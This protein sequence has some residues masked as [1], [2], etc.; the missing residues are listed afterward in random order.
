MKLIK[1]EVLI[2]AHMAAIRTKKALTV[3]VQAGDANQGERYALFLDR[4]QLEVAVESLGVSLKFEISK[5][6]LDEA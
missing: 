1:N 4:K 2:E 5:K 3:M 6:E